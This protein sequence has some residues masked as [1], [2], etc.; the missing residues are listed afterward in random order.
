MDIHWR[1]TA[2][3]CKFLTSSSTIKTRFSTG[4]PRWQ[5]KRISNAIKRARVLNLLPYTGFLKSYHKVSLKTIHHD[6]EASVLRRVDIETGA[7]KTVQP[8]TEWNE[9]KMPKK[10]ELDELD[11]YDESIDLSSYN[12]TNYKFLSKD[13]DRLVKASRYANYLKEKKLET[14]GANVSELKEHIKSH[15]YPIEN[16]NFEESSTAETMEED[17]AAYET[18]LKMYSD[19]SP[20]DFVEARLAEAGHDHPRLT[21]LTEEGEAFKRN[22]KS[23]KSAST[24]L[25]ELE[26]F[27]ADNGI[28]WKNSFSI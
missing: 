15:L 16:S 1:N 19:L 25:D 21:Q 9:L 27:K 23:T 24:L 18:V 12:L 20:A 11:R 5:Q 6:I 22:L 13:E 10:E 4:L 3:L 17:K 14:S 26:K 7:L 2:L 8:K 28:Q